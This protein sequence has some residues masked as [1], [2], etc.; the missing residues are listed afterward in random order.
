MLPLG[1]GVGLVVISWLLASWGFLSWVGANGNINYLG[2]FFISQS[3]HGIPL[4]AACCSWETSFPV[5]AVLIAQL[6]WHLSG[7]SC[8]SWWLS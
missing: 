8:V 6:L 1:L 3:S 2:S 5:C 7:L 4:F